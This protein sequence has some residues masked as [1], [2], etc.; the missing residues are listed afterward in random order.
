MACSVECRM[1]T[2]DTPVKALS[3]RKRRRSAFSAALSR[4]T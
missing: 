2:P 1:A 3:Y 4:R